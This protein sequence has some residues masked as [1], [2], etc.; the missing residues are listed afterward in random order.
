MSWQL[1]RNDTNDVMELPEDLQWTDEF[2]WSQ[3]AQSAPEYTLTGSVFIQQ[4][5]KK[6][7]RP[8]TLVGDW[9]WVK[10]S[11]LI[12]LRSW[13]DVPKLTMILTHA[14]GQESNVMWRLHDTAI[15]AE[16]VDFQAPETDEDPYTA[17]FK[18][19]TI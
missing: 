15:N 11:D 8:I 4:G 12:V 16:P 2:N 3:I 5:T 17:T 9:A 14:D 19:M 13:C 1:K 10:R 18:L 6:A 7:G